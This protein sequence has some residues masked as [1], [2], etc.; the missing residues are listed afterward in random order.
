MSS[1][2]PG[3]PSTMMDSM[4]RSVRLNPSAYPFPCGWYGEDRVFLM[5]NSWHISS[6]TDASNERPWSLCRQSGA[7]KYAMYFSTNTLATVL[8]SMLARGNAA[9]HLVKQLVRTR[10]Y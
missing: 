6:T 1:H 4:S 9:V 5:T 2:W 7:P 8:A 3:F 10:S